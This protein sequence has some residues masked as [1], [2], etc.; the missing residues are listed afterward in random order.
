MCGTSSHLVLVLA[1]I[2]AYTLAE[3]LRYE[4]CSKEIAGI[5]PNVTQTMCNVS[6]IV[7]GM[8]YI[9]YTSTQDDGKLQVTIST[10]TG[11][12]EFTKKSVSHAIQVHRLDFITISNLHQNQDLNINMNVFIDAPATQSPA[13]TTL[14]PVSTQASTQATTPSPTQNSTGTFEPTLK[15][16]NQTTQKP[17]E[18]NSR[19][20]GMWS[21]V[22]AFCLI[23]I[24][25]S[26]VY[27]IYLVCNRR[28]TQEYANL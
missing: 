3:K 6:H 9:E 26:I 22:S 17:F 12:G 1:C 19:T 4:P 8:V 20:I 7:D 15:P 21:G 24:V 2:I 14:A 25:I 16:G 23:A 27:S 28:G 11:I 13:T 10:D 5:K 18:W